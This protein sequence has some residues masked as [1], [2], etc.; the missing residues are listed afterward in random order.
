M[1]P[2]LDL[3]AVTRAA[4]V[5]V[6]EGDLGASN[7]GCHAVLVPLEA[8]RFRV[9]VDP[10]ARHGWPLSSK[11]LHEDVR[12]HRKRFS[13]GHELAHTFFYRRAPG[14][15]PV[16]LRAGSVAEEDFCDRFAAELL[17]PTAAALRC[18]TAIQ[19]IRAQ[20]KYD[21]SLE[22]AV[23][24]WA[25]AHCEAAALFVLHEDRGPTIQWT[26]APNRARSWARAVTRAIDEGASLDTDSRSPVI[27]GYRRQAVFL[28]GA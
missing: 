12:R 15:E 2:L 21:V 14:R 1:A 23:R 20:R 9:L 4:G 24:A 11:A 8:D 17:F 5:E 18:Q 10:T 25:H 13:V 3:G 7:G 19:L 28:A 6:C 26:S 22:V 27:L 16:R